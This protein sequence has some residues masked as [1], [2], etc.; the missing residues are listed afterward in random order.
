MSNVSPLLTLTTWLPNVGRSRQAPLAH[1]H[2]DD[3]AIPSRLSRL[4]IVG[5]L[6]GSFAR[7]YRPTAGERL[8]FASAG[9]Q[10]SPKVCPATLLQPHAA[11]DNGSQYGL[12]GEER[13]F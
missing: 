6:D 9:F 11:A 12:F 7:L 2:L 4:A 13:S 1:G 10:L 3:H 8:G 5:R